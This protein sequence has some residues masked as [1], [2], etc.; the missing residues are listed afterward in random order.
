MDRVHAI[1]YS[2]VDPALRELHIRSQNINFSSTVVIEERITYR[3]H[4][5]DPSK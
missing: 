1:E 3:E 2:Q 4:P 5:D